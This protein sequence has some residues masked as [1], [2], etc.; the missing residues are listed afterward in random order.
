MDYYLSKTSKKYLKTLQPRI[1]SRLIEAIEKLP[2][3]DVKK[4]RGR[5]TPPLFRLR[6]GKYRIIYTVVKK[7]IQVIIIDTRGDIYKHL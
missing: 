7:I 1:A 3:G 6:V 2:S 5:K 4:I